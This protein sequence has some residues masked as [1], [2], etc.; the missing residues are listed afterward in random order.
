[1]KDIEFNRIEKAILCVLYEIH[2]L[3]MDTEQVFEIIEERG[4]LDMTDE[5]FNTYANNIIIA[6]EN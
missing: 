4:L 2:P 1:M 6:K 5:E 3:G